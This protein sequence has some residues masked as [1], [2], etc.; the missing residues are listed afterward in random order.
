[1]YLPSRRYCT[2]RTGARCCAPPFYKLALTSIDQRI[3]CEGA[4]EHM[5]ENHWS[6]EY[7][8]FCEGRGVGMASM[9][10]RGGRGDRGGEGEGS[11]RV[12]GRW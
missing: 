6:A 7:D 12:N 11:G 10:S 4:F 3:T 9:G 2:C 8:S 5:Q 1:M